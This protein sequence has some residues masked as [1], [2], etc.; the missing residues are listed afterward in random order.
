VAVAVVLVLLVPTAQGQL[1][2]LA[3][4]A[5]L[6]LFPAQPHLMLAAVAP[7]HMLG[8]VAQGQEEQ[9][10]VEQVLCRAQAQQEQQ[11]VVAVEAV[12]MLAEAQVD[13]EL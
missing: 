6:A 8:L 12:V 5:F 10:V 13:L 4:L 1:A 3:E 7:P 2:E 11:I 9:E